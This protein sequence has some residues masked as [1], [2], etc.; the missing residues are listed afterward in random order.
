M[1]YKGLNYIPPE[2]YISNNYIV[3]KGDSLYSIARKLNT[4]VDEL[5]KLNNLKTNNLSIGQ[6]LKIPS[7]IV[8]DDEENI[9]IVQSGDTLYKIAQNY[10]TNV[11]TIKQ[12]NNLTSNT[13]SVGQLLKIP[14]PVSEVETYTVQSGDTLYSISQKFNTSVEALKKLNNIST[15]VLS[16]GQT[17]KLPPKESIDTTETVE[18]ETITYT[19]Q[20]GDSLY[21]L[22]KKYNTTV[23]SIKQINKLDNNLLSIGQKLI[24]PTSLQE[25]QTTQNYFTHKVVSGDSLYSIAK[26]YNTTVD[27]IKQLN[28]LTSNLLM[29]GQE[30]KIPLK[31]SPKKT[32]VVKN[33]DSLYSIAKNFDTTVDNLKKIN[34]LTSNML[35]IGQILIIE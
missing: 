14:S 15:N 27:S 9:Y 21:K 16:V 30:I 32:Y 13:L 17:I 6:I 34:N 8:I 24:I 18:P 5:K 23:D 35:S 19:V 29:I 3:Q 7:K 20:S 4:T 2:G 25:E 31:D 10:N 12:L 22:A 28:N 1:D 26:K 33:G 11:D